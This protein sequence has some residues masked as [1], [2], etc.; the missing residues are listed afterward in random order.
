MKFSSSSSALWSWSPQMAALLQ[1]WMGK[2][3]ILF[4]WYRIHRSLTLY[5]FL[6]QYFPTELI[7]P[8]PVTTILF[9]ENFTLSCDDFNVSYHCIDIQPIL[10]GPLWDLLIY[11][12]RIY[13]AGVKAIQF[14]SWVDCDPRPNSAKQRFIASF[15]SSGFSEDSRFK[16][17]F[18]YL[19]F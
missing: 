16:N 8:I 10:C 5:G 3:S 17:F 14:R 7:A 13:T 2:P 6:P 4:L 9:N 12:Y 15:I 11:R 19:L 18:Y 1:I